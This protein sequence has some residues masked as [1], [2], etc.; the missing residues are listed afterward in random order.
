MKLFYGAYRLPL[1]STAKSALPCTSLPI[2]TLHTGRYRP[3]E[4][5]VTQQARNVQMWFDDEGI[6]ARFLLRDRD[7]KF[8]AAFDQLFSDADTRIV[9]TPVG[10]QVDVV[11]SIID[12]WAIV[13]FSRP[14]LCV[15]RRSHLLRV[16]LGLVPFGGRESF[17]NFTFSFGYFSF[18]NCRAK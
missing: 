9:K 5:W 2:P 13:V 15:I 3:N 18:M 12:F 6:E 11:H 16:L 14:S 4:H 10:F 8:T 17:G 7:T 1:K